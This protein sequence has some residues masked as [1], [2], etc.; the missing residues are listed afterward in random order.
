VQGKQILV[1]FARAGAQGLVAAFA[2]VV[3]PELE[4]L[5][6]GALRASS[7]SVNQR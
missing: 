2:G 3:E 4:A 6:E 5:S 7:A 1:A